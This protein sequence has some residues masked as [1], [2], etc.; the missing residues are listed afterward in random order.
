MELQPVSLGLATAC[1]LISISDIAEAGLTVDSL[2]LKVLTSPPGNAGVRKH[3]AWQLLS[4]A[5]LVGDPMSIGR[6]RVGL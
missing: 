6:E 1:I 2:A 3:D 5:G 4:E